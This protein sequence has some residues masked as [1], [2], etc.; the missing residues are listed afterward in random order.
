MTNLDP[1]KQNLVTLLHFAKLWFFF[2]FIFITLCFSMKILIS[3]LDNE[4]L[5]QKI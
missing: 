4:L 3:V 5:V 1:G 2:L